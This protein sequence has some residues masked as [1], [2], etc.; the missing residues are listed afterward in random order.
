MY[1]GAWIYENIETNQYVRRRVELRYVLD[2]LAILSRGPSVGAKVV[3]AG[4]AEL[5]GTEFG[6]GK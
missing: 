2:E 1:G 3:R 6:E 5:F 4:A